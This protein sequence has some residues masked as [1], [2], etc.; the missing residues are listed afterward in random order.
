MI[1]RMVARW[2]VLVVLTIAMLGSRLDPVE[3][4]DQKDRQEM[5]NRASLSGWSSRKEDC[6]IRLQDVQ[7]AIQRPC[8][9]TLHDLKK[10]FSYPAGAEDPVVLL[11]VALVASFQKIVPK[12]LAVAEEHRRRLAGRGFDVVDQESEVFWSVHGLGMGLG[13]V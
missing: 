9:T 8:G 5:G 13:G 10:R 11:L 2:G 7:N 1:S 12:C 6:G 3:S 4:L